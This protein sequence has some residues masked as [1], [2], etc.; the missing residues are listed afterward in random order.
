[1]KTNF[2]HGLPKYV[3]AFLLM[4]IGL[5]MTFGFAYCVGQQVLRLSAN[6]PQVEIADNVVGALNQGQPA[7]AL[8]SPT[9]TD[10][11][12][13]LAPFVVIF[14]AEGKPVASTVQL[15]GQTPSVPKNILDAA[16]AEG[17]NRVTWE[18]KEGVKI[19]SVIKPYSTQEASG[20]VLAGRSLAEVEKRSQ[21]LLKTSAVALAIAL[22]IS[23]AVSNLV[24]GKAE[25]HSHEHHDHEHHEHT[26]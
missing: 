14:D 10:M 19:A 25:E 7:E 13:G 2:L 9:P 11:T 21:E 15:D 23:L 5:V 8:N 1:M 3:K 17:E 16:K 18:P 26:A 24:F 20:F 6:D 22:A 12:Q 4:G